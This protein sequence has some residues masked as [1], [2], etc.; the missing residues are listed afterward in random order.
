LNGGFNN[1][2]PIQNREL[3]SIATDSP[4]EVPPGYTAPEVEPPL[5]SQQS[6]Q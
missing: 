3:R 5:D 1:N 6:V 2:R 4:A